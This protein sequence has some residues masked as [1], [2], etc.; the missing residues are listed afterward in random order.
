[1]AEIEALLSKH[2][3]VTLV[4]AGGVGKTSLS[5][6]VGAVLLARFAA[7]VAIRKSA[8]HRLHFSSPVAS[9]GAARLPASQNLCGCRDHRAAAR[10]GRCGRSDT[11]RTASVCP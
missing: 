2:R 4:G 6:Q 11:L 1:V 8:S 3:F 5:L 10:R 9:S 7:R